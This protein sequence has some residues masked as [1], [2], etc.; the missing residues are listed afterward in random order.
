[1]AQTPARDMIAAAVMDARFYGGDSRN[2]A[3][4]ANTLATA[5]FEPVIH[6]AHGVP[7]L[8]Y[9]PGPADQTWMLAA[10]DE[11]TIEALLSLDMLHLGTGGSATAS[12]SVLAGDWKLGLYQIPGAGQTSTVALYAA[13]NGNGIGDTYFIQQKLTAADVAAS[14][15]KGS[16]LH[17]VI[18]AKY[19]AATSL[20]VTTYVNGTYTNATTLDHTNHNMTAAP[21]NTLFDHTLVAPVYLLRMW[22]SYVEDELVLADLYR[23]ARQVIPG[24]SFPAVPA[25]ELT[26]MTVA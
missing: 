10:Q 9:T 26:F 15:H 21:T 8:V 17:V 16:P 20:E 13:F 3:N 5:G 1:M 14:L 25:S 2:Y 11:V 18:S 22:D 12:A 4:N 23:G 6:P 24:A 19:I 7:A